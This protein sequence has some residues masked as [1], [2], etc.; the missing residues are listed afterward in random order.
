VTAS[1]PGAVRPVPGHLRT[2]TPRLVVDDGAAAIGF[3]TTAFGAQEIRRAV[4]RAGRRTDPCRDPDR[5]L[6]GV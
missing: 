5:G 3:Y 6:G 2:V 1:P 4:H